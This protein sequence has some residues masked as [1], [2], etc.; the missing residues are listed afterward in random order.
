M[1]RFLPVILLSVALV[2]TGVSVQAWEG[3][4]TLSTGFGNNTI[5]GTVVAPSVSPSTSPPP[6]GG[7]GGGGLAVAPTPTPSGGATGSADID[8]NGVVDVLDFNVLMVN[9]GSSPTNTNADLNHDGVV[10]IFDFNLFMVGW[11]N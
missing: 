7:G 2:L 1:K 3:G 8:R 6:S 5:V 4:G 10:D 9:W 11:P